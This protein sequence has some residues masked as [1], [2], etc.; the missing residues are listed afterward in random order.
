[1]PTSK[2]PSSAHT[3]PREGD[4]AAHTGR[5]TCGWTAETQS[6]AHGFHCGAETPR[7]MCVSVRVPS[8]PYFTQCALQVRARLFTS[9]NPFDWVKHG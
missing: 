4:Y 5:T 7:Y 9:T 8:L 1:M 2:L 6:W 3:R